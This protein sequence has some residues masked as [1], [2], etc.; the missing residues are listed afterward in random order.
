M[1]PRGIRLTSTDVDRRRP[2]PGVSSSVRARLLAFLATIGC[3]SACALDT[4]SVEHPLPDSLA[5]AR[6]PGLVAEAPDGPAWVVHEVRSDSLIA[7]FGAREAPE[8][9]LIGRIA[10]A[11]L[12]GDEIFVLDDELNAVHVLDVP[13]RTHVRIGSPGRGPGEL[14][15]PRGLAL[16]EDRIYVADERQTIHVFARLDGAWSWTRDIAVPFF[17]MDICFMDDG[18]YLLAP[19]DDASGFIHRLEEDE[20]VASFGISYRWDNPLIRHATT[21]GRLACLPEVDGVAWV[22]TRLNEVHMY[23]ADGALRRIAR[24]PDHRPMGI[25]ENRES[26]SVAMGL[27]PGRTEMHMLH[28]VAPVAS[29]LLVQLSLYDQEAVDADAPKT[30]RSYIVDPASGAAGE[31]EF[32]DAGLIGWRG[33]RMALFANDPWPKVDVIAVPEWS[34]R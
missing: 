5:S 26:G 30:I 2:S 28:A 34:G 19:S 8:A 22:P 16:S 25:V 9:D 18:L 13:A 10:M 7:T 4:P 3:S 21:E 12:R 31:I 11:K 32:P 20:V 1:M 33:G 27:T 6:Y 24:L 17:P 23:G 15:V 29:H 14:T